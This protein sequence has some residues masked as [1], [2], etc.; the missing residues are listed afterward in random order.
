MHDLTGI[1]FGVQ[2]LSW[3]AAF[4]EPGERAARLL[5][6]AQAVWRTSGAKVD[7]TNAYSVFDQLSE[8]ALRKVLG[9]ASF[10]DE[11]FEKAFAEGASY[12][13]EEAVALALGEDRDDGSDVTDSQPPRPA[14]ERPGGLTRR[15]LEIAGLLAEGLTNKE[16]A[17]RL[18]IS[19]RT[20]ETHVDRILGKLGFTSRLQVAS[21]MAEQQAH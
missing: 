9:S 16:I 5:G 21:W 3:C 19:Q 2:A 18:V 20:V 13:F 8:E 4:R 7:E 17:R 12:S 1:S 14:T 15:E 10:K 6:A 11:A